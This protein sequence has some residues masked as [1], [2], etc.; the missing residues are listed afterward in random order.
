VVAGR[1]RAREVIYML[2]GRKP[3]R[4]PLSV[5]QILAW[6][7]AHYQ[8]TGRWPHAGSGFIPEA[9]GVTWSAVHQALNAGR[10][11]LPGGDT[12][13]N[14]LDRHRGGRRK[15]PTWAAREDEL[16]RTL[17]PTE[18]ARWTGRSMKAVYVRRRVLGIPTARRQWTPE[19]DQLALTMPAQEVTRRT[20][21]SLGAVYHRRSRLDSLGG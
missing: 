14:L 3:Y 1:E 2:R 18:V 13:A 16:V 10:W 15:G 11:G 5:E 20:G 8:R 7:D 4:K 21:R 6:A 19:E 17:P 9:P 12:L